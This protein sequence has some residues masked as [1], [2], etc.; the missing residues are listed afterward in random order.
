GCGRTY[1]FRQAYRPAVPTT[2]GNSLAEVGL[3][4][5]GNLFKL[6]P[7]SFSAEPDPSQASQQTSRF[8]SDAQAVLPTHFHHHDLSNLGFDG[9]RGWLPNHSESGGQ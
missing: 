4:G 2:L 5:R 3:R 9:V 1:P 6:P 7:L 8:H